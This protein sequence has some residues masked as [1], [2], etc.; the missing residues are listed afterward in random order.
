MSGATR[1]DPLGSPFIVR[2]SPDGPGRQSPHVRL[3]RKVPKNAGCGR[4]HYG[5][6]GSRS[7][8]VVFYREAQT[9]IRVSRENAALLAPVLAVDFPLDA[10][11]PGFPFWLLTHN[12]VKPSHA[13]IYGGLNSMRTLRRTIRSG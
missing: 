5:L 12:F 7:S 3:G 4:L 10:F 2:M 9:G 13:F 1:R 6:N 11:K 8:S